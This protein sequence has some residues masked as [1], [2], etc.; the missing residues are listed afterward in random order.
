MMGNAMLY[1]L[2]VGPGD[3]ELLTVKAMRLLQATPVVAFFAAR[4]RPGVARNI[5]A[6][7]IPEST[8][9]MRLEY[10]VTTEI[11]VSDPHYGAL[12]GDFYNESAE[13]VAAVLDSR[14]DLALVCE[15]DPLFYGSY[16]HVHRRLEGRYPIEVVPG[17]TGMSG[18]WSRAGLPMTYGDDVLTVVPGT[19]PKEELAARIAN[20]D[21][22][23]VMKLGRN[24]QKVR[25][26]LDEAGLLERA[27]YVE[28]GTCEAEIRRPLRAM[29]ETK[30]PY[31]SMILVP[32]QGRAP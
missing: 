1:G 21:A 23:V 16:M 8:E 25:R 32:G 31:F 4:S 30:A 13:R 17:I 12:M 18:C 24:L 27:L 26:A 29:E 7:L 15:G 2:G 3:P 5:L 9:Q 14:R 19:L 22:L 11:P 20:C 10:P 6:G 28:S